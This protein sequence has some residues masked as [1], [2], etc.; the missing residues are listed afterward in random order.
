MYSNLVSSSIAL[1][2]LELIC[3]KLDGRCA[4]MKGA[5]YASM[6]EKIAICVF[7]FSAFLHRTTHA[8]GQMHSPW[9]EGEERPRGQKGRGQGGAQGLKN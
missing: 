7:V 9:K 4:A 1:E 3:A 6:L 5:N 8:T 2:M